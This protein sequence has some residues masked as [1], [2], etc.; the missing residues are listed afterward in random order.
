MAAAMPPRLR[1]LPPDSAPPSLPCGC[2][3][4]EASFPSIRG[5]QRHVERIHGGM[6]RA[7]EAW[8]CLEACQPHCVKPS[9]KRAVI[10]NFSF[11]YSYGHRKGRRELVA[12]DPQ[13]QPNEPLIFFCT[14][15]EAFV[16]RRESGDIHA[17]GALAIIRQWRAS[18]HCAKAQPFPVSPERGQFVPRGLARS[19]APTC[20]G[21]SGFHKGVPIQPGR[22]GD[23]PSEC[24]NLAPA[25][26]AK[27]NPGHR[28]CLQ[29]RKLGRS[30]EDPYEQL[31]TQRAGDAGYLRCRFHR[32]RA[33]YGR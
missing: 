3:L 8:L 7:R 2:H 18:L 23:R 24:E 17:S 28:Y 6:Q 15:F 21:A 14:L 11:C 16:S 12:D 13:P 10:E 26:L 22:G 31:P 9:E 1:R 4:C 32:A 30:D 29:Q 27:W 33:A 25:L 20:F 5:L 19:P